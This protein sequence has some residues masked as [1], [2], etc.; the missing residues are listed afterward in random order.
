MLATVTSVYSLS[1]QS[2]VAYWTE[3]NKGVV[4]CAV[5]GCGGSPMLVRAGS[6]WPSGS[7]LDKTMLYVSDTNTKTIERCVLPSCTAPTAVASI[8]ANLMTTDQ[9]NLYAVSGTDVLR[10]GP[11]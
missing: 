8:A 5:Q 10:V 4:G 3:S 7:W 1:V 6:F 9:A 11:K 2:G